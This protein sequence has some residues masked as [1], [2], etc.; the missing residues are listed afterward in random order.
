MPVGTAV[1]LGLAGA[2]ILGKTIAARQAAKGI[3]TEEDASRLAELQRLR[4]QDQL[5]LS[6]AERGRMEAGQV[7]A[8]GAALRDLEPLRAAGPGVTA[9]EAFMGGLA[10]TET[11]AAARQ[12]GARD[13]AEADRL[14]VQ[15]QRAELS[16]LAGLQEQE[17]VAKRQALLAGLTGAADL[18]SA[19]LTAS[20]DKR[21]KAMQDALAEKA[22]LQAELDVS[23][24][25]QRTLQAQPAS[26]VS[27]LG[28]YGSFLTNPTSTWR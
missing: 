7:V 1:A 26:P 5:G 27:P 18:G 12:A 2:S 24:Q 15:A 16:K 14:A 4:S 13:I 25:L 17:K 20:I 19:A 28:T 3:F 11:L 23:R 6:A 21:E 8:R 10:T 9:R 22:K